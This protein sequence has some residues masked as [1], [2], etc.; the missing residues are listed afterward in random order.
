MERPN[1]LPAELEGLCGSV[2][3]RAVEVRRL[4]NEGMADSPE[5]MSAEAILR[6]SVDDL[7]LYRTETG[8]D[9]AKF[10]EDHPPEA[11]QCTGYPCRPWDLGREPEVNVEFSCPVIG[12]YSHPPRTGVE[13]VNRD[14]WEK[15]RYDSEMHL[16]RGH[17]CSS[18]NAERLAAFAATIPEQD[19][20]DLVESGRIERPY[21]PASQI[22]VHGGAGDVHVQQDN[23]EQIRRVSELLKDCDLPDISDKP[24]GTT[25][26]E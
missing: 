21:D 9:T 18:E 1:N 22:K 10:M 4:E 12:K 23:P 13:G 17:V 25:E 6:I 20:T 15:G 14:P 24:P 26:I 16:M 19:G 7:Q 2:E 3:R 5:Y 8:W 11:P